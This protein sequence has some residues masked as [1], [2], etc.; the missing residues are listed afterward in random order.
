MVIGFV[1]K[2]GSGK[3]TLAALCALLW[4]KNGH[5]TLAIDADHNQHLSALLG[6][7]D[8]PTL[9]ERSTELKT[10][11]R[12][13]NPRLAGDEPIIKTTPPG[14]GSRLIVGP[15]DPFFAPCARRDSLVLVGAGTVDEQDVGVR[16][17]HG[18]AGSAELLLN[19]L[20]L[21]KD[22]RAFVDMT[23]GADALASGL[24]T[25][26]DLTVFAVEPTRQS[27][28]VYRE[29]QAKTAN[30]GLPSLVVGN[31]IED[32]ADV[33]FLRRE[34]PEPFITFPRLSIVKDMERNG[35]LDPALL[36]NAARG[37]LEAILRRTVHRDGKRFTALAH[38]YHR[39]NAKSWA[40]EAHGRDLTTHI[41][42]F[43][44]WDEA[45]L[46]LQRTT[47]R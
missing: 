8:A 41:D 10:L 24:F 22:E 18:K 38:D 20:V 13:T 44:D 46:S 34:L 40:N 28:D 30:V 27:L 11:I 17:Y 16:C 5:P 9:H 36:P 15:T 6:L 33:A 29:Y 37:A 14:H 23:A 4:A 42:P 12:G 47:V 45:V 39:R 7:G 1:G 26:F 35:R 25:R 2:G 21:L 43:F 32:E 31:K 3:S 19:H